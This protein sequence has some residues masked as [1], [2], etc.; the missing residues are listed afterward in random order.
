MLNAFHRV[1]RVIVK[2][3]EVAT[4]FLLIGMIGFITVQII[5]RFFFSFPTPWAEEAAR[6]LMIWITF[7]GSAGMLIKGEHLMVDVFFAHF[8]PKLKRVLRIVYDIVI[9]IFAVFML[10]YSYTLLSNP[11]IQRGVT[12]ILQMPLRLYYLCLPISMGLIALYEVGETAEAVVD[13]IHGRDVADKE[14]TR[15]EVD[16]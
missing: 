7:I 5:L 4:A 2:V 11:M 16:G 13:L 1:N 15:K 14:F 8:S 6:Y 12:P 9:F 3:Q 10:Y